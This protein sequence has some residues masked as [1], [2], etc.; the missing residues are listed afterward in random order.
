MTQFMEEGEAADIGIVGAVED[1][2]RHGTVEQGKPLAFPRLYS[3]HLENEDSQVFYQ[4]DPLLEG[5]AAVCRGVIIRN[6]KT[7]TE[8][9]ARFFRA[10]ENKV[11]KGE[12]C[13][14]SE[15]QEDL[16]PVESTI[17]L[18]H[19]SKAGGRCPLSSKIRGAGGPVY[20]RQCRPHK[21]RDGLP[22]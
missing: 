12:I 19:K 17:H 8:P 5:F 16:A 4:R 22:I 11:I 6:G 20:L 3:A 15:F 18:T 10:V 21:E 9:L 2:Y 1:H 7:C 13:R 14:G